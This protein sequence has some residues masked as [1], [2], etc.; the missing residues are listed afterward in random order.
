M[1]W[2]ARTVP[3]DGRTTG[4]DPTAR[5]T[6]RPQRQ[7]RTG[8]AR[9]FGR[10]SAVR[11]EVRASGRGNKRG[12][13]VSP[14][15]R[16]FQVFAQAAEKG[17]GDNQSAPAC[18]KCDPA[19][20]D[21]SRGARCRLTVA[22]APCTAARTGRNEIARAGLRSSRRW[23]RLRLGR[24]ASR[25]SPRSAGSRSRALSAS[26]TARDRPGFKLL[27]DRRATAGDQGPFE[28]AAATEE[29]VGDR[30]RAIVDV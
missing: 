16:P 2:L 14:G 24:A 29:A 21:G 28:R 3:G 27:H 7:R 23:S 13:M 26:A 12:A 4:T 20:T 10:A 11:E 5:R 18:R 9:F 1:C 25:A 19:R 17:S 8:A 6:A 30:G 15:R 22:G